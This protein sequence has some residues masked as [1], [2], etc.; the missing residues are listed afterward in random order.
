MRLRE[1]DGDGER[2]FALL[3]RVADAL[4]AP[5][6]CCD[7]I[8]YVTEPPKTNATPPHVKSGSGAPLKI[9]VD[10]TVEILSVRP[11]QL[12]DRRAHARARTRTHKEQ[13]AAAATRQ[14][15]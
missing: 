9:C 5:L 4:A 8:M 6:P 11:P 10:T 12:G 7:A 15:R 13:A 2:D 3:A 1:G 14:R